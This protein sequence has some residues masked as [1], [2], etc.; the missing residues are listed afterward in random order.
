MKSYNS[1]RERESER[2]PQPSPPLLENDP[3]VS[4]ANGAGWGFG[5]NDEGLGLDPLAKVEL[6]MNVLNEIEPC[7]GPGPGGA[8]NRYDTLT[9]SEEDSDD[10]SSARSFDL[11]RWKRFYHWNKKKHTDLLNFLWKSFEPKKFSIYII[12]YREQDKFF[13]H[14]QGDNLF[15]G[16]ICRM[17]A[18]GAKCFGVMHN[19]HHHDKDC[20]KVLGMFIFEGQNIPQAIQGLPDF[21]HYAFTKAN[22]GIPEVKSFIGA[23]VT[24]TSPIP[25]LDMV[26]SREILL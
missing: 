11:Q 18:A 15:T 16:F 20:Y 25:E 8:K 10:E 19:L 4:G 14:Y 17:Q 3:L 23:L 21:E 9:L 13:A 24:S 7:P 1:M 22:I 2:P 12:A 26:A 6:N 5:S